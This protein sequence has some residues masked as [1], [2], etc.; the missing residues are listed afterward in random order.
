MKRRLEVRAHPKETGRG[1][2][3]RPEEIWGRRTGRSVRV[4]VAG[5]GVSL[6]VLTEVV[7]FTV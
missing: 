1:L 5:F 2:P 3:M 7:V 6:S 4:K